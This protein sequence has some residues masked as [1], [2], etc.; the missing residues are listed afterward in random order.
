MKYYNKY[1]IFL[2]LCNTAFAGEINKM[3]DFV[4]TADKPNTKIECKY[5][6]SLNQSAELAGTEL[7][8]INKIWISNKQNSVLRCYIIDENQTQSEITNYDNIYGFDDRHRKAILKINHSNITFYAVLENPKIAKDINMKEVIVYYNNLINI[9]KSRKKKESALGFLSQIALQDKTKT[10]AD[11]LVL[12]SDDLSYLLTL[13]QR[14]GGQIKG[15]TLRINNNLLN[16]KI[17]PPR[18]SPAKIKVFFPWRSGI[19]LPQIKGQQV[20]YPI[21]T[22]QNQLLGEKSRILVPVIFDN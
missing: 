21:H 2:L 8:S 7:F 6:L 13:H 11:E 20:Y 18:F 10:T 16:S 19:D 12:I 17:N 5:L 14:F 9:I 3:D 1:T 22:F 15:N 4:V